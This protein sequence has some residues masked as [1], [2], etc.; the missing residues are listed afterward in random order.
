MYSLCAVIFKFLHF[1]FKSL[2]INNSL[3]YIFAKFASIINKSY[4]RQFFVIYLVVF[5]CSIEHYKIIF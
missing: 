5:K 1:E 4:A 2:N 3:L